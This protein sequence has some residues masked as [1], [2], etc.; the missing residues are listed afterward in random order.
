M[1]DLQRTKNE[2][3]IYISNSIS[4]NTF[5]GNETNNSERY[6]HPHVHDSIIYNTQH[7]ERT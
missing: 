7:I 6:L 5:K 2:A 3:T 4:G 1:K